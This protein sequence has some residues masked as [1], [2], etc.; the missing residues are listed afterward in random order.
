MSKK[1]ACHPKLISKLSAEQKQ[2]PEGPKT[3]CTGSFF[4]PTNCNG[5]ECKYAVS[6]RSNGRKVD[7]VLE[8][9]IQRD[10]W[11]GIGFSIDGSMAKSDIIA[12]S[13]PKVPH[14]LFYTY[15]RL[16]ILQHWFRFT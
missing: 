2:K 8:T 11:S 12:I 9:D 16:T 13:V 6:W 4:Y 1:T 10:H 3:M 5:S 14:F 7:F 15:Y